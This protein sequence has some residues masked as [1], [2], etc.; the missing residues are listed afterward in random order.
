[1][2]DCPFTPLSNNILMFMPL[3]LFLT[4]LLRYNLPTITFT[5]LR[6]TSQ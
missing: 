6:Y 2:T 3:S 4:T 5:H 1:M